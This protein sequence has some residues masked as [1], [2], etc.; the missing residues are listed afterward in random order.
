MIA[1][2]KKIWQQFR[3]KHEGVTWKVERKHGPRIFRCQ[4]CGL[5][6]VNMFDIEMMYGRRP[7]GHRYSC[8]CDCH[9]YNWRTGPR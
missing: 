5:V 3:C 6:D 1:W 2:F 9:S 8:K 4:H 7:D